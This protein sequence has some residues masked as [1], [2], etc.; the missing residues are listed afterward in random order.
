MDFDFDLGERELGLVL[1]LDHDLDVYASSMGLTKTAVEA[2][3]ND[4]DVAR[5]LDGMEPEKS[6][7]EPI[8]KS[9][10][11]CKNAKIVA[12]KL[13]KRLEELAHES[14]A[15]KAYL[16]PQLE[17]LCNIVSEMVNF[18]IQLA[19]QTMPHID[20]VRASKTSF[21]LSKVLSFVNNIASSTV[22][23]ICK[24]T[25]SWVSLGKAISELVTQTNALFPKTMDH[26]NIV[27]ITGTSPW[28]IRVEEVKAAMAVNVE[29]ERKVA[30]LNEE[31]QGLVRT[32]KIKD[33]NIQESAVKIELME[34]RMEGV[35]KQAEAVTEL[36]G[37]L[38][39]AQK[40]E[41]YY[42][43]AMEQLQSE[44]DAL[45]KENGKL[46]AASNVPEKAAGATTAQSQIALHV[47]GNLETTHLLEL[48]ES[49]RGAIR[50]LRMENSYLKGNDS[51]REL[52]ELPPLPVASSP[53][54]PTPPLDASGLSDTDESDAESTPKVPSVRSLTTETKA[55][56]REVIKFS[57]TPRIVDLSATK[58]GEGNT[59]AWVPKKKTP[60]YQV[61]ERKAQAA[62]LSRRVQGLLERTSAM[63]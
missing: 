48:L 7:L 63:E 54:L 52:D 44:F 26:E 11:Q 55:L 25:T 53:R 17:G 40:Q 16:V 24:D 27:K 29:A 58:T 61:W 38:G 45:A 36:E 57:S 12:R 50:F 47:D 1:S 9:L 3:L 56:Y 60:T 37:L 19:Q 46:K 41:K 31:M 59:K 18:G 14:S 32:L 43:E 51:M 10:D 28:I 2:I 20:E 30:Q 34:R 22:A 33:Q 39:K 5:D 8:Q 15:L 21:Q 42:V 4:E 35:K 49:F 62:H 23:K 13:M 6:F